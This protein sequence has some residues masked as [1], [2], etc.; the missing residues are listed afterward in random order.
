MKRRMIS[1]ALLLTV[2]GALLAGCGQGY[3]SYA[4]ELTQEI[5]STARAED[6]G[7]QQAQAITSFGVGLLQQVYQA[8]TEENLLLSPLSAAYA[9]GMTAN[10]AKGQTLEQMEQVL[11]LPA[12]QLS[13]ALGGYLVQL[14][15]DKQLR[16][17]NSLWVNGKE[18][19][20]PNQDFLD[21]AAGQYQAQVFQGTFDDEML[22]QINRWVSKKTQGRIPFI[23]QELDNRDVMVLLNAL[24]FDAKWETPY[25]KTQIQDEIFTTEA[26]EQCPAKMMH[27]GEDLYWQLEGGQGFLKPYQGDRYAFAALLPPE[28]TA[29][30]DFLPRITGEGLAQA[31]EQARNEDVRVSIPQFKWEGSYELI[32]SL[33]GLGIMDAFDPN[34]AD[35]SALGT[36][37]AGPIYVDLVRQKTYIQVD[38]QGTKAAASTAIAMK[39]GDAPVQKQ[40]Y[41]IY[42][43][44]P[45]F[46]LLLDRQTNTPL[47][48]GVMMDLEQ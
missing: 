45:F 32:E 46:Y 15:Q 47:M 4:G 35:F 11:G 36:S 31:L 42:L 25:R 23:L 6:Y 10:G 22:K 19:F 41:E 20:H 2:T 43:D 27:S 16:L 24:Y 13:Q 3:E 39:D 7:S 17:A 28:G 38:D 33:K 29:M 12:D 9:L 1:W 8:D 34:T 30:A 18:E 48:M 40:I 37:E 21:K 26:G 44:R 5:Q 14:G